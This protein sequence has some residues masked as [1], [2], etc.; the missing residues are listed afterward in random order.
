[1]ELLKDRRVLL[2]GGAALA[3]IAGLGIALTLMHG[4][5][6]P[7]EAPPASRGGL[8]VETG[9]ADDT[10]LDP[11]RP[12][13]CFVGGQFV[14]E[15]TLA[16]CAKKNGVATGAL[17]VGVDETGALA[18]ADQA[19]LVLTPLPPPAE[20][21]AVAAP[22]ATPTGQAPAAVSTP[23]AV[24]WRYAG[25]EWRKQPGE[26]TLNACVQQLYS[27]KCE[28]PGGATYGRWGDET[29]RRVP[30]RVESS[31]DNR[32]FHSIIEQGPDCSIPSV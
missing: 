22:A 8:V 20:T 26:I 5:K 32:T 13:R 6:S 17:D 27:G 1:M 14:G 24:C 21:V 4:G 30:G 25:G 9:R 3:L 23:L 29:L 19:G 18:A 28:R 7:T 15:T 12:L 16:E 2:G 31:S 10:K 11:A